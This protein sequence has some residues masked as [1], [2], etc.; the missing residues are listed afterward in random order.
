MKLDKYQEILENNGKNMPTTQNAKFN[1]ACVNILTRIV[2][3][4]MEQVIEK[5]LTEDQFGFRKKKGTREAILSLRQII[6]K[7]NK[8]RKTT[9]IAFIDLENAFDNVKWKTI[10]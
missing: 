9:F 10:F 2:L 8:K 4:R 3:K 1:F 7:Q 6:E 5:L